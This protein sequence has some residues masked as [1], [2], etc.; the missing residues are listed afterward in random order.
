MA[1]N[2][3]Q[4]TGVDGSQQAIESAKAKGRQLAQAPTFVHEEVLHYLRAV[5]DNEFDVV[6]CID[7]L[8]FCVN[9][10]EIFAELGRVLAPGGLLFVSFQTRY[11]FITTLARQKKIADAQF[12]VENDEGLLRLA[13]VPAY[14]NWPE[15]EK[16]KRMHESNDLKLLGTHAIGRYCGYDYDGTAGILDLESEGVADVFSELLEIESKLDDSCIEHCRF[17]FYVSTK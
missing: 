15:P 17:A 10:A 12:A 16:I 1:E 3:H 14:Y 2:G 6:F 9:Y 7:A 4:V 13:T 8:P 11:Y 5:E